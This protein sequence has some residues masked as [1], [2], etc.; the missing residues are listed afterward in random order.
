M[1]HRCTPPIIAYTTKSPVILQTTL[2]TRHPS[3]FSL[4]S[5]QTVQEVNLLIL[6]VRSQ[7]PES[8]AEES[9]RRPCAPS[10][11]LAHSVRRS[12]RTLRVSPSH[13]GSL[14]RRR[15]CRIHAHKHSGTW[16]SRPTKNEDKRHICTQSRPDQARYARD[17]R[18]FGD[19]NTP[20]APRS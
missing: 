5:Q 11:P 10:T 8:T 13:R 14:H 18:N 19:R 7:S 16:C 17:Y 6:Q 4:G 1:S 2:P 3:R 15:R 9:A 12:S 20:T